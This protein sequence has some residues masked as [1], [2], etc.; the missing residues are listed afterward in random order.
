MTYAD[1]VRPSHGRGR[2]FDPCIAH[3]VFNDLANS[4][5]S[6]IRHKVAHKGGTWHADPCEIRAKGSWL[7]PSPTGPGDQR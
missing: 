3:H 2:R 4:P 7:V 6:L 5:Q 1:K